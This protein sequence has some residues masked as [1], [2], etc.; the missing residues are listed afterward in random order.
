VTGQLGLVDRV[1]ALHRVDLFASAPGRVLLAVA[2]A[3]EEVSVAPG[4]VLI[5]E[6]AVEHHLFAII[7]GS[8]QVTRSGRVLVEQGPGSTVGELAVLVP[9]ARAASVIA[10]EP[11]L[12]LRIT[13]PILDDLLADWPELAASV[14]AALVARLRAT[15]EHTDT[16]SP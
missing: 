12:A 16:T 7:E 11:T 1:A 6:G 13:K 14:I 9:E 4:D 3:A 2:R 10:V 8:V 5:T 15:A